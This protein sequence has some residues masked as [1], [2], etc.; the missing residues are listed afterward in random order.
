MVGA[1]RLEPGCLSVQMAKLADF[2]HPANF[3]EAGVG[4]LTGF[5]FDVKGDVTLF[6]LRA[7]F[8]FLAIRNNRLDST[9]KTE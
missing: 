8:V 1:G 5:V 2:L 6:E 4:S 7:K 9:L 3:V